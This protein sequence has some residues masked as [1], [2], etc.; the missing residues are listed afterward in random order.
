M[1]DDPIVKK[2]GGD[3]TL[4]IGDAES[5]RADNRELREMVLKLQQELDTQKGLL[6]G[7]IQPSGKPS[8]LDKAATWLDDFF[9]S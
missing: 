1:S 4:Q 6:A 7:L 8:V 3:D 2:P 9:R 5:L